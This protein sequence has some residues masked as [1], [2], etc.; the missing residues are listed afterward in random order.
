MHDQVPPT[1]MA[2]QGSLYACKPKRGAGYWALK[3]SFRIDAEVVT[4]I[5]SNIE[6]KEDF[7]KMNMTPI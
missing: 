5:S 3:S 2:S 6:I 1:A 7:R 4:F